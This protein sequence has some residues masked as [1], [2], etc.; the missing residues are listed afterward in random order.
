[1]REFTSQLG[2]QK[3]IWVSYSEQNCTFITIIYFPSSIKVTSKLYTDFYHTGDKEQEETQDLTKRDYTEIPF[4]YTKSW[5][6][7]PMG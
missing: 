7:Q 3:H 4:P 2:K 1:V 5:Q 6:L